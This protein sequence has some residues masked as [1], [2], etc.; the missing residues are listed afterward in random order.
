MN[1]ATNENIF[2]MTTEVLQ[3]FGANNLFTLAIRCENVFN[4]K[5]LA[6]SHYKCTQYSQTSL[7]RLVFD[8][9]LGKTTF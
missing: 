5:L 8:E 2:W 3:K 6:D 4:Y 9:K 7:F 1:N